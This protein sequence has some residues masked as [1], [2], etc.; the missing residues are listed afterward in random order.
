VA[1]SDECPPRFSPL[2]GGDCVR[3]A[4]HLYNRPD[5]LDRLVEAIAEMAG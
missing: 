4:P 5:E 3:I 2:R 1:A